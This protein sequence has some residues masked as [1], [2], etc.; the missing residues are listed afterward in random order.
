MTSVDSTASPPVG[1]AET[2]LPPAGPKAVPR[3]RWSDVMLAL[4]VREMQ[5]RASNHWLG[6]LTVIVEPL[7]HVA[8]LLFVLG[9]A[10]RT[11]LPGLD[12]AVFFAC[13]VVSFIFMR[14]A[15]NQVGNALTANKPLF[16]YRQ[17]QPAYTFMSR[18]LLET[19][20]FVV[21][22]MLL[23]AVGLA[24]ERHFQFAPVGLAILV[25]LVLTVLALG[26]GM[27]MALIHHVSPHSRIW[28]GSVMRVLYYISCVFYPIFLLPEPVQ[29]LFYVNPV[30]H[31]MELVRYVVVPGYP[32]AA[33][34][35]LGYAA[36]WALGSLAVGLVM[37]RRLRR[38]LS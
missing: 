27:V 21:N 22:V 4:L 5:T 20:L 3:S 14:T 6:Y 35:S 16:F 7:L 9:Q 33:G 26:L 15:A 25:F 34:V 32:L 2:G 29:L 11:L 18:L 28:T 8:V 37:Y 12:M 10:G 1:P 19:G 36:F 23:A 24:L 30:V 38:R 13:G 17:V 31:L